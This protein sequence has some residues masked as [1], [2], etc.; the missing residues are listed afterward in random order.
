MKITHDQVVSQELSS[1]EQQLRYA[2]E[3]REAVRKAKDELEKDY[4]GLI[5]A[6]EI[7]EGVKKEN[8]EEIRRYK[9]SIAAE[10]KEIKAAM[11]EISTLASPER[12]K[13]LREFSDACDRLNQLRTAGFFDSVRFGAKD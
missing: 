3:V 10:L 12:V 2:R 8:L 13:Q 6:K 4:S 5:L 9:F 1:L 7:F 11:S